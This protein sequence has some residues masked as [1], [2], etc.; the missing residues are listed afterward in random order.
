MPSKIDGELGLAIGRMLSRHCVRTWCA[1]RVRIHGQFS[2]SIGEIIH[3]NQEPG[4]R[5]TESSCRT[6]A[7]H[8]AMLMSLSPE[9]APTLNRAACL[10][11]IPAK[12]AHP[13]FAPANFP[14]LINV[15]QAFTLVNCSS[16]SVNSPWCCV[17]EAHIG[18][19][20]AEPGL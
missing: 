18:H 10:A 1:Y 12:P 15:Y 7:G 20:V 11:L 3:A 2:W 17:C 6:P 16:A 13:P 4:P 8:A 14:S 9:L 19:P 5:A